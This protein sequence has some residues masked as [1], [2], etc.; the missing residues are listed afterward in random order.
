MRVQWAR[1]AAIGLRWS[2]ARRT[3]RN[4]QHWC[5]KWDKGRVAA[6]AVLITVPDSHSSA[7]EVRAVL[8]MRLPWARVKSGPETPAVDTSRPRGRTEV[9]LE[10]V[11]L[12]RTG[13]P[14]ERV[15]KAPCSVRR[16][17]EAAS[18]MRY[19]CPGLR[20]KSRG[21]RVRV[22]SSGIPR[23]GLRASRAHVL[24][25]GTPR[26]VRLACDAQ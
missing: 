23:H 11:N 2:S 9:R 21:F 26:N 15:C 22:T 24:T 16:A 25:W 14:S 8:R 10:I 5:Q 3:G 20:E 18:P 4:L 6:V 19:A 17:C 13:S 7:R 1:A 12:D